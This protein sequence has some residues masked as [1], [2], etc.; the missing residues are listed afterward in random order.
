MKNRLNFGWI[1][2]LS[3]LAFTL[4]AADWPLFRGDRGLT[5]AATGQLS[6]KLS[7]LWK[8]DA[9]GPVK[10]SAVTAHA[11]PRASS[12]EM[13]EIDQTSIEGRSGGGC[14]G[15]MCRMPMRLVCGLRLCARV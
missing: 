12:S 7:L 5:G 6:E 13:T 4:Q 3:A 1:G 9:K 15:G 11:P 2:I 14:V 8:F 10:A